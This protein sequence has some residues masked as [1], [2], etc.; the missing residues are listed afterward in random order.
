MDGLDSWGPNHGGT[1]G[2]F[3]GVNRNL[4][5]DRLAGYLLDGTKL[6]PRQRILRAAR[7]VADTGA[8]A[9]T[10]LMSTR[11]WGEPLQR[12]QAAGSLRFTKVPAAK[13][14]S[15]SL[16]VTYEA[17]EFI[18]PT[19]R[20]EIFADPWMPDDVERCVDRSVFKLGSVGELVHWDDDVGPDSPMVEESADAREIRMVGDVCFYTEA[21]YASCRVSVTP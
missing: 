5:P 21:P 9:D 11:N 2:T 16:G 17:I 14:G 4:Y 15:I 7:I 10:Y 19:G 1:P 13:V 3:R 18:G 6:Q 8:T 12:S 20:I